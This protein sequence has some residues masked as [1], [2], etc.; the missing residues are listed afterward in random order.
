[1]ENQGASKREGRIAILCAI[2]LL[3]NVWGFFH[4]LPVDAV[5]TA[6]LGGDLPWW[7]KIT[8][9]AI[10]YRWIV[11]GLTLVFA[12]G[13]AAVFRTARPRR[14]IDLKRLLLLTAIAFIGM[15]VVVGA[16]LTIAIR[17][18]GTPIR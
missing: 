14:R 9:A 18:L 15:S 5:V 13:A 1:M 3:V 10:Y 11:F 7:L 6:S 16:A 8:E 12:L 4:L 17:S 2:V